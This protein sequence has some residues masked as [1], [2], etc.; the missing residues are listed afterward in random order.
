M[1]VFISNVYCILPIIPYSILR[2][3]CKL[4]H[5]H[6]RKANEAE[7]KIAKRLSDGYSQGRRVEADSV[8]ARLLH[9]VREEE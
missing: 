5:L 2:Y 6:P 9:L 8:T 7:M 3:A 4:C 1:C